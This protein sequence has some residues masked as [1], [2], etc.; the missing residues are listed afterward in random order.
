MYIVIFPPRK[1]FVLFHFVLNL[2][3]PIADMS[4]LCTIL[5]L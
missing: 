3:M 4:T 5:N 1:Y 2:G